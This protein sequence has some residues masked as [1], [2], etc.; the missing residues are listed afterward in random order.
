MPE[1]QPF[2]L[3]PTYPPGQEQTY[4]GEESESSDDNR[5]DFSGREGNTEWCAWEE[6]ETMATVEECLFLKLP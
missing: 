1:V 3:E 5:A 6:C 4:P 2:Q